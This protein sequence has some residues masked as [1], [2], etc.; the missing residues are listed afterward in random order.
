MRPARRAIPDGS[1]KSNRLSAWYWSRKRGSTSLKMQSPLTSPSSLSSGHTPQGRGEV[2]CVF[3]RI[4]SRISSASACLRFR[5]LLK[6]SKLTWP[7]VNWRILPSPMAIPFKS[8]S[9]RT[10][11][12]TE[13]TPEEVAM[14]SRVAICRRPNAPTSLLAVKVRR[15][16]L[17]ESENSTVPG[18]LGEGLTLRKFTFSKPYRIASCAEARICGPALMRSGTEKLL[19]L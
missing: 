3:L 10:T 4:L 12:P 6:T 8:V 7:A 1:S 16:V 2:H 13:L 11:P 5:L 9:C 17:G 14:K 15:P 19:P 18:Q